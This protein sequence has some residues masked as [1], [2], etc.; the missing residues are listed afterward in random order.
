MGQFG[1]LD[2][3]RI[4]DNAFRSASKSP[5]L[6]MPSVIH[7]AATSRT[8]C[9][10]PTGFRAVKAFQKL[11]S[12]G[13][14]TERTKTQHQAGG[15]AHTLDAARVRS[16]GPQCHIRCTL[17]LETFV[18]GSSVGNFSP[19]S[20]NGKHHAASLRHLADQESF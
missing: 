20:A 12:V 15:Q 19:V 7:H 11:G 6:S 1:S 18:R 13:K 4:E 2:L 5:D 14:Q 16:A 3:L 9:Y 8:D 10:L 17:I